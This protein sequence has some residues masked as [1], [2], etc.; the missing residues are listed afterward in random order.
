MVKVKYTSVLR[1][2]IG[3]EID[4]LSAAS[5]TELIDKLEELHGEIFTSTLPE[6]RIFVNG[7]STAY[8]EGLST[9]LA[10]G[11]EVIFMLPVAGG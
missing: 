4:H 1:R 9:G 10:D 11:D 8:L 7:S 3:H 6:C 5:V 2:D